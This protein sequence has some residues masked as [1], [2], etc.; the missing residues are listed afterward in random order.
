M[1]TA[2]ETVTAAMQ[3]LRDAGYVYDADVRDGS[4]QLRVDGE[5]VRVDDVDVEEIHRFEGDSNPADSMIVLGIHS[6]ES[7]QRGVIVAA[8]GADMEPETADCL[9]RLIDDR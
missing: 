7:G 4:V 8:Y 1:A 3:Q 6:N 2:P 9:H 5:W